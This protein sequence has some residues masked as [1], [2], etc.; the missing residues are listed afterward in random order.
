VS[1]VNTRFDHF[2]NNGFSH[3]RS[4]SKLHGGP[5]ETVD[6]V[7]IQLI[8]RALRSNH[9]IDSPF[10]PGAMEGWGKLATFTA[11]ITGI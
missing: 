11:K 3:N 2:F 1:E 7:A 10:V 5:R 9:L 4:S 6:R 8:S